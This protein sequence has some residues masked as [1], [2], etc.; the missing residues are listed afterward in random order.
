MSQHLVLPPESPRI[1]PLTRRAALGL[2]GAAGAV[3]VAGCAGGAGQGGSAGTGSETGTGTGT[4]SGTGTG[5]GTGSGLCVLTPE[6]TEGPYFVDNQLNRAD[7]RGGRTGQ[8]LNLNFNIYNANSSGCEALSGVQLDIWHCDAIGYYSG[9]SS[10][11]GANSGTLGQNWLRGYQV[12]NDSGNVSFVTVYPGWYSGRTT[13]IHIKA[14][15]YNGSRT[16]T[17]TSQVFF[18]E[19]IT[20]TVYRNNAPYNTH[21]TNGQKDRS[22]ASDNIYREDLLL[23]LAPSSDGTGGYTGSFSIG[24]AV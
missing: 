8:I 5:T 19:A 12:S 18:D 4:G 1:R 2:L 13:H 17:A 16:L 22:N 24:I 21:G 14:R 7:I 10:N 3:A 11:G 15:L 20:S 23:D 9:V 6:V